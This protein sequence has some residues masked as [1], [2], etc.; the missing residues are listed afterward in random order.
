MNRFSLLR[1]ACG[2]KAMTKD[3]RIKIKAERKAWD[4]FPEWVIMRKK[5]DRC[6]TWEPESVKFTDSVENQGS[7]DASVLKGRK[8]EK[9]S[10]NAEK[11]GASGKQ[12]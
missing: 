6:G 11:R 8:T 10:R 5:K 4:Y 9:G 2:S 1:Q 12:P 3:S 7:P